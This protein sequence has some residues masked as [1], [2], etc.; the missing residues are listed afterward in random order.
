MEEFI[1]DIEVKIFEYVTKGKTELPPPPKITS[2]RWM[3]PW[4]P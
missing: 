2:Y 1:S 4:P 3:L